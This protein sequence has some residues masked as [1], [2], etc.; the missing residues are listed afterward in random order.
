M[1]KLYRGT[2]VQ[3]ITH[4]PHLDALPASPLKTHITA[5]FDQL[6][7]DSDVPPNLVFVESG[8]VVTGPDFAFVGN[9]GLLSDLYEEFSPGETGFIRP[10][11]W[12]SHLPDLGIY[13]MLLLV[14]GEDGYFIFV[15][16]TV[17]DSH[18]DL[19]W[20]LTAEELGGLSE[21]QPL[22]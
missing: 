6:S 9:N 18:S 5:R 8:G 13:E 19:H 21:P 15:P 3:L 14:N 12:V 20:V 7:E 16:E 11:E 17:V 22:Y 1:D 4:R 2:T 10:F